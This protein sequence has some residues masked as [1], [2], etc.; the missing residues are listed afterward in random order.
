[1]LAQGQSSSQKIKKH[2][3]KQTNKKKLWKVFDWKTG[4]DLYLGLLYR[5]NA[6]TISTRVT[7]WLLCV[8]LKRWSFR[9]F[10]FS[11]SLIERRGINPPRAV[12]TSTYSKIQKLNPHLSQPAT[13][14]SKKE[15][16]SNDTSHHPQNNDCYHYG[17]KR[18]QKITKV[19]NKLPH[20]IWKIKGK[21]SIIPICL[22]VES[23][24]ICFYTYFIF[25]K[26]KFFTITM[27]ETGNLSGKV[28]CP[29]SHN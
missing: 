10:C 14:I 20:S 24:L 19:W 18:E 22:F 1:M 26:I 21:V 16:N 5:T 13:N 11:L 7:Q 17:R 15:D 29:R 9:Q 6:K 3:F 8:Q 25:W 27:W 23:T 12:H 2:T 4:I 28:F